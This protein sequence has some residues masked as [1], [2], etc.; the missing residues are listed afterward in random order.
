MAKVEVPESVIQPLLDD[1]NISASL[2]GIHELHAKARAN[3]FGAASQLK[4]SLELLG[5]RLQL[6]HF[7]RQL[8]ELPVGRGM[9]VSHLTSAR[10]NRQSTASVDTNGNPPLTIRERI[11]SDYLQERGL[12]ESELDDL[13]SARE[14]R[15][16]GKE[17]G[18]G[19]PHPR[20]IRQ[21]RDHASGQSRRHDDAHI[22]IRRIGT[23]AQG[24]CRNFQ[25]EA[26]NASAFPKPSLRPYLAS[27]LPLL[28]EIRFAAIEELTRRGLRRGTTPR[29]GLG[30]R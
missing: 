3:D 24:Q 20:R 18:G 11:E 28:S 9:T 5:I 1:L 21:T 25:G 6:R 19:G 8:L 10:Y 26:M 23:V 12:N 14:C 30:R 13:I 2:A 29:L 7:E 27:D 4:A 15:P 17:L 22:V 16:G